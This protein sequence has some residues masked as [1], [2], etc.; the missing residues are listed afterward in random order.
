MVLGWTLK[1]FLDVHIVQHPEMLRKCSAL[2][3]LSEAFLEVTLN[4]NVENI[5]SLNGEATRSIGGFKLPLMLNLRLW[6]DDI[7]AESLKV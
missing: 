5:W 7:N 4:K 6:R 2:K 3:F 1:H